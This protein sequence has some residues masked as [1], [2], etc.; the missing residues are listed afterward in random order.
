MGKVAF[1]LPWLSTFVFEAG[2]SSLWKNYW[3]NETL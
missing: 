1:T 3:K 2:K